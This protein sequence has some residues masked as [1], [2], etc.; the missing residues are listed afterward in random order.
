MNKWRRNQKVLT[1][2]ATR[3]VI[4][5]MADSIPTIITTSSKAPPPMRPGKLSYR[6]WK[7]EVGIWKQ[8]TN[9]K[10]SA[11]GAELYLSLK[12]EIARDTVL[13]NVDE[14]RL[15]SDNGV[16]EVLRVLDSIFI[17]EES[18]E[19]IAA[20]DAFISF[21]RE[22]QDLPQFLREFNLKYSKLKSFEMP[23]PEPLLAITLLNC[24][25]LDP[26]SYIICKATA[27]LTFDSMKKQI[28]RV[29]EKKEKTETKPVL[30]SSNVQHSQPVAP[31]DGGESQKNEVSMEENPIYYIY[32][33]TILVVEEV[34]GIEDVRINVEIGVER[35]NMRIGDQVHRTRTR[36]MR[37][38][39][40]KGRNSQPL[41]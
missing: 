8:A 6:M 29:F 14:A 31:N 22:S 36:I 10:K 2:V 13:E 30:L 39:R 16:D 21:R 25:N 11:Q 26:N 18:D 40:D 28:E 12:D 9:T 7:K 38:N 33:S 17:V 3:V 27:S 41:R 15:N 1:L 20:W 19:A 37:I 24:A 23:L 4:L 34:I 32:I 35:P 5:E